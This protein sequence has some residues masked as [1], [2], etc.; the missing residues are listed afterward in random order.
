LCIIVPAHWEAIMGGSQY[1][2]KLIV[3]CLLKHADVEI[4]YLTACAKPGFEPASYKIVPFS[5]PTGIR[6]YGRF[7]DVRRLY[8]ALRCFKPDTILQFVG[9]A[10]TGIAAFYAKHNDARMIFRVTSDRSVEPEPASWRIHH[11]IEREFLDYG[12]RKADLILAQTEY[13][14]R[15]LEERFKR[16]NIV[17][18]PNIQPTPPDRF[19]PLRLRKQ[20]AWIANL[21]PLKNPGAFLR[22]AEQFA[23]RSDVSFVMIGRAMQGD[24]W[25]RRQLAAIEAAKNVDYLGAR[26]QE[27]VN[28]VLD[29]SRLLVNT[30]DYEG[31]PNTFIQA[32]MRRV[33]V[34]S[35]HVNPDGLLSRGGLG[36]VSHSEQRLFDDVAALLDAPRRERLEIGAR[37]R[38]Y[39]VANHSESNLGPLLRLLGVHVAPARVAP[40]TA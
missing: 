27:E 39:A 25:T 9:T 31:F 10:H 38:S 11:R 40:R 20:V 23:D 12:I 5:K 6:R 7:F 26:S 18:L 15:R 3:D 8:E 2:A 37:C 30:S 29:E 33:P 21:K 35:L 4:S 16:E 32:W 19:R 1:Q 34:V 24:A 13:Q 17:V 14:R 22:L 36:A 28:A